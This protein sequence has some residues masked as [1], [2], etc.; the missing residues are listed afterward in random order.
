MA[1]PPRLREVSRGARSHR[2]GSASFR[3]K[4][5]TTFRR[6]NAPSSMRSKRRSLA[7]DLSDAVELPGVPLAQQPDVPANLREALAKYGAAPSG[8]N[9]ALE[10]AARRRGPAL[11]SR[12]RRPPR[13]LA[14]LPF[15]RSPIPSSS[16]TRRSRRSVRSARSRT[17]S[18]PTSRLDENQAKEDLLERLD[19]LT[20]LL[21]RALDPHSTEPAPAVPAAAIAPANALAGLFRYP[22]RL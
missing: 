9:T 21:V 11:R 14:G 2:L 6:R 7:E 13:A 12:Q 5:R 15:S 20:V 16:T 17:R 10:Q 4:K 19:R 3:R 1:H 22:L 18:R 8:L